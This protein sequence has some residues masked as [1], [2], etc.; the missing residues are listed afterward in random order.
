MGAERIIDGKIYV[1]SIFD[2]A[3]VTIAYWQ[4]V[5]GRT[6]RIWDTS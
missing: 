3:W 2:N 4:W 5:N 1:W 6:L